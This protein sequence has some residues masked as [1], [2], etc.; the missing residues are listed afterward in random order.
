M[1]NFGPA[2]NLLQA[3]KAGIDSSEQQQVCLRDSVALYQSIASHYSFVFSSSLTLCDNQLHFLKA[4]DARA[5]AQQD[6]VVAAQTKV[7]AITRKTFRF[8]LYKFRNK[9]CS[10]RLPRK[11]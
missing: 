8:S 1:L 9:L 6:A 7:P 3:L 11:H 4:L 2:C 10:K 5:A